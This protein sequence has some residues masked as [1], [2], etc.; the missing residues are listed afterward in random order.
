MRNAIALA[1]SGLC[2]LLCL[3]TPV[4]AQQSNAQNTGAPVEEVLITGS[5]VKRPD[6]FDYP[7]P[8]AV[9]GGDAIN[10]SG[11]TQL[12]DALNNLPQ[13]L[14][15]TGSQNTSSSLFNSGQERI[16]LR[17]VGT[18]RT[19]VLVD[20]RRH[21]TGDFRTNAVDLNVIP[22]TMIDRVEAISGGASAVYGSEAI[23]GVVNVILKHDLQGFVFDLQGGQTQEHDGAEWKSS[24]SYGMHFADDRGNF[25]IGAEFGKVQPIW[26]IDRDWAF[27]GIRRNNSITPQTVVPASRSNV[28]PTAAFQYV[29]PRGVPARSVSIA[30]D[31][32]AV[33]LES[34][35][36]APATVLATCQDPWLFYTATYNALQGQTTR[37]TARAYTDFKITDNIKAFTDFTFARVDGLGLFQPAFSN[38]SG[39]PGTMP[40]AF[41]G[42]NGFMAGATALDAAMRTQ[43]SA[44]GLG[45]TPTATANVGKFW[46]EFGRRDAEVVRQSYRLVSGIEGGFQLLNH[47]V[48]YDA[49][50]QYSELDGYTKAFNVPNVS[51]VQQATDAVVV[52]GQVV[53]RDAAA[54]AAG[55]VPWDLINGPSP[56]AV[57]WANANARSNGVARQDIVGTNFST[58]LFQLP[59]GPLGFAIGGEYRKEQSDQVQDDLSASGA[60][61]YNA[62]G[63]TKGEYTIREGYTELVIPLLADKFLAHRLSIEGAERVGHYSTV[64]TVSQ[65]RVGMQWAPV[66]DLSFRGSKSVS[67]RAPN[68]AELFGPQAQN[69]TTNATDPCEA[70]QINS[71]KTPDLRAARIRNCSAVI[72]N[73]NPATFVSNFGTNRSSLA[74]LQG[75]N[76]NLTEE[77]ADTWTAGLVFQPH[78]FEGVSFSADLW[79]IKVDNAVAVIP[80]NTLIT[81]LCYESA[82]APSSNRFCDLI[83]RDGA[84]NVSQVVLT[85]QN[86]QAIA[87]SGLDLAVSVSHNF[88]GIGLFRFRADGTKLRKWDLQG[89]PADPVTHYIG[90]LT[91]PFTATPKY[92]I[93]GTLGWSL[94]KFSA[95]WETHYLSS[96]AVSETES[97]ASRD[98][99]TTGNYWEHDVHAGYALSDKINLRA[100]IVNVTNVDPPLVPE[101]GSATG[102]NVSAYDNRGRWYFVGG[103][104]QF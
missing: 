78:W 59:A 48:T 33:N 9:I 81:N 58:D 66:R 28:T 4:L 14:A 2:A 87:T 69:F 95:Q 17:G 88:E 41:H 43:W 13:A 65:W 5:R 102:T 16:D 32:S 26:Q 31:R 57:T 77:A 39:P 50:A 34:A 56:D 23:A 93:A 98:P 35:A 10:Q 1:M 21:L 94:R 46:A 72:P 29:L 91:G 104:Y 18:S 73:Y 101:V 27:P 75:G 53:C 49:Y 100:G 15:S 96:M 36:C 67:V 71:A 79:N 54:R 47:D 40:V 92:K 85:N 76:P 11:Y 55:C 90:T 8:V 7:V 84:G 64:G 89:S 63:R 62:I 86:V 60:L 99:F 61:F 22:S 80:I 45:F 24:A 25:L 68:I 97:S 30:L 19:L 3:D 83:H 74:L 82:L 6:G 38:A 52:G 44:A 37:A 42:D 20:G 12:G 51:R 103:S 70:A